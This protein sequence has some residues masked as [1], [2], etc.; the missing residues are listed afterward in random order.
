MRQRDPAQRPGGPGELRAGGRFFQP[1]RISQRLQR[2]KQTERERD[3]RDGQESEG[4]VLEG[5]RHAELQHADRRQGT[6]GESAGPAAV[7][8]QRVP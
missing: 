1:E 6:P 4:G 2:G 5:L 8:E 3:R 7:E